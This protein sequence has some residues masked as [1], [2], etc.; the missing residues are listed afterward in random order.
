MTDQ[1]SK[2]AVLVLTNP[3]DIVADKVIQQLR[4]NDCQVAR[5]D[6]A[7]M[8]LRSTIT[9][10]VGPNPVP[11]YI[12]RNYGPGISL[13]QVKSVWYRRPGSFVLPRYPSGHTGRFAATE[14]AYALGG[15][16][17]SL[18]CFWMNKPGAIVEADYKADQLVRAAKVGLIV[19]DTRITSQP[20]HAK[21]FIEEHD[22]KVVIKVLGDPNIYSPDEGPDLFGNIF[23]SRLRTDEPV[24]LD[25]V[26]DAPVF[27]QEE[28]FK[29]ADVRVTV[30]GNEVYAVSIDSQRDAESVV[31][32]RRGGAGLPHQVIELPE[33]LSAQLLSL[34]GSYDLSFAAIDLVL[35]TSGD[36]VFL[37]LNANG[38][39]GWLERVTGLDISASVVEILMNGG[40][41]AGA[42]DNGGQ[43]GSR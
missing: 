33:A 21:Q 14:L 26:R 31:D 19:P 30:V 28:I 37:E 38:E 32:W 6:P 43:T 11:P 8:P 4:S 17:R 36:Y 25:R 1:A 42:P 10:D 15:A 27:L 40:P 41:P 13:D 34:V 39:W 7:D 2:E 23:T 16:L 5:F 18:D 12:F 35:S 24:P 9:M 3:C 22:G 29:Q 20:V